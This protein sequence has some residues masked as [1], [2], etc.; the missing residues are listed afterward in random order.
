MNKIILEFMIGCVILGLEY[1]H[2][3]N[4]IHRDLKP[5]NL[6]F[7]KDGY[8]Q[9]GDLGVAK[10]LDKSKEHVDTSGT[11]GYMAPETINH[12][13][14]SFTSD[15]FSIGIILYEMIMDKV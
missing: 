15:F 4:I 14:H 3:N 12:L 8:V 9:I 13:Q 1:L 6:I 2:H 11:P 5:E 10:L 7:D